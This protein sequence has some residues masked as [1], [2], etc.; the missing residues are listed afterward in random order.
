MPQAPR[1]PSALQAAHVGFIEYWRI[2]EQ[3]TMM[4]LLGTTPGGHTAESDTSKA[5]LYAPPQAQ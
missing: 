4:E 5:Q 1:R 3:R 2:I